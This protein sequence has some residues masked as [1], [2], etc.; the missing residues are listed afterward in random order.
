MTGLSMIT[1]RPDEPVA[2]SRGREEHGFL[3]AVAPLAMSAILSRRVAAY[4]FH[5]RV[6]TAART[7]AASGARSFHGGP[8]ALRRAVMGA[9][10]SRRC[11]LGSHDG[12]ARVFAA[13]PRRTLRDS[14]HNGRRRNRRR[15]VR[16]RSFLEGEARDARSRRRP[17]QAGQEW[18]RSPLRHVRNGALRGHAQKH[19][20]RST[21]RAAEAISLAVRSRAT[22]GAS[23]SDRFATASLEVRTAAFSTRSIE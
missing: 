23:T 6:D 4:A 3:R 10:T 2:H 18:D 9:P 21:S 19:S 14:C 12:E 7:P 15:G 8:T 22:Q 13:A 1:P 17:S 20:R 5:G 11:G 16:C